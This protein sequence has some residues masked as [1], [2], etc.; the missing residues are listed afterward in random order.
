MPILKLKIG[1]RV[2]PLA[3]WQAEAV[4]K[5]LEILSPGIQIEIIGIKTSGDK[6]LNQP[7]YEIGGKGL[8][9]KE[10]EKALLQ[11]EIDLAVHSMKDMPQEIA[12]GL[13]LSSIL[14]RD[15]V[16]DVFVSQDFS[17]FHQLPPNSRIG[18]SSLRRQVL[19]Q[20]L[21]PD[22]K[23]QAIRGNIQTRLEKINQKE[24][25][26]VIL[27]KAGLERMGLK[28][29]EILNWQNFLPALGQG[30]LAAQWR[31]DNHLLSEFLATAV[32]F[33][34]ETCAR[35]ER[36]FLKHLCGNCLSPVGG[37]ALFKGSGKFNLHFQGGLFSPFSKK[38]FYTTLSGSKETPEEL[39]R[40]AAQEIFN[41]GGKEVLDLCAKNP[42]FFSKG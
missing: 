25:D 18:T 27:A 22:L 20:R 11:Q 42:Q 8:F 16:E 17:H 40:A 10:L 15:A 5:K 34:T 9:V 26:A 36:S 3:W 6:F 21:R 33:E 29:Q 39:G 30:A 14:K 38:D 12:A 41:Q 19:V 2:S 24:V 28:Y 7:L 23:I 32:D 1:S 37:L 13:S 35:V 31:S 4:K